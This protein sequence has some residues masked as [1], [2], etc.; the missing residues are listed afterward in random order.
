[1]KRFIPFILFML[2][3]ACE[4]ENPITPPSFKFLHPKTY[5]SIYY[6]DTV[7][8]E[9]EAKGYHDS[10][11]VKLFFEG[12]EVY[13]NQEPPFKYSLFAEWIGEKE[14]KV[15]LINTIT[16]EE[17]GEDKISITVEYDP[18]ASFI[19]QRD[20][21]SY[22]FIKIGEQTWMAENLAYLPDQ[23]EMP[24][25]S[26]GGPYYYV[27]GYDGNLTS[28]AKG[29]ATYFTYGV[30]YNQAA[31]LD[32]VCPDGWHVS[33]GSEWTILIDFLGENP[34]HKLKSRSAWGLKIESLNINRCGFDALPGGTWQYGVSPGW[35]III[36]PIYIHERAY[37]WA[38][39]GKNPEIEKLSSEVNLNPNFSY[40]GHSIRCVKD[41]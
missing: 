3:L 41:E 10:I 24:L 13:S 39:N 16:N 38:Q 21:K 7:F 34:G 29:K 2:I 22:R 17:I 36:S 20:G 4:N 30:I 8:V 6:R 26:S 32:S 28:Q 1:M 37:F 35:A 9:I 14:L 33:T 11:E 31:S 5:T 23:E 25:I 15:K 12:I 27:Y 19:D 40:T 18:S